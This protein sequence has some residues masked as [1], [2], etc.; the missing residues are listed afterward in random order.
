MNQSGRQGCPEVDSPLMQ[1]MAM[2]W[3]GWVD[4]DGG[5]AWQLDVDRPDE[6]AAL[7]DAELVSLAEPDVD[8]AGF[9]A[10]SLMEQ[11]GLRISVI[12]KWAGHADAAF[13]YR[14]YGHAGDDLTAGRDA[15]GQI[16]RIGDAG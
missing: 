3:G 9:T 13:T 4:A 12:S 2:V 10:I 16:C 11:A 15:L 1:S 14:T 7:G 8:G 5:Q 6:L